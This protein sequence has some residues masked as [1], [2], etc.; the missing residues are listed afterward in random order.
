MLLEN[1]YNHN[2]AIVIVS[3]K[4]TLKNLSVIHVDENLG[5]VDEKFIHSSLFYKYNV[6]YIYYVL[7]ENWV[8]L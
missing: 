3:K 2:E 1:C 8:P 4:G 6:K 7:I 5:V